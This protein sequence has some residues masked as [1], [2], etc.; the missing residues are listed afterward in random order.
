MPNWA[1]STYA[2]TRNKGSIGLSFFYKKQD[3]LNTEDVKKIL[4]KIIQMKK[5]GTL[6][7]D[8]VCLAYVQSNE[9]KH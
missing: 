3:C 6:S 5:I 7:D 9:R 4:V 8:W 2:F 1:V